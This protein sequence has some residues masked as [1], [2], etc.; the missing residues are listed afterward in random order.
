MTATF[1]LALKILVLPTGFSPGLK[2]TIPNLKKSLHIASVW[3]RQRILSQICFDSYNH[4]HSKNDM[5]RNK[6]Q[7]DGCN[8]ET[9]KLLSYS[10]N[11][12]KKMQVFIPASFYFI[13][14]AAER[15]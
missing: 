13:F 11:I 10:S 2:E 14:G 8:A 3:L 15:T 4:Q 1:R 7:A 6:K 5:D 12:N 9:S